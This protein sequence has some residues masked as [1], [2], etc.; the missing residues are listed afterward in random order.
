MNQSNGS[1][2]LIVENEGR[3]SIDQVASLGQSE[4]PTMAQLQNYLPD[5]G[6]LGAEIEFVLLWAS[7]DDPDMDQPVLV[8]SPEL[9]RKWAD[10]RIRREQ[11]LTK[12]FVEHLNSDD[13]AP[14]PSED[15]VKGV[16]DA[17]QYF[18]RS[19]DESRIDSQRRII[20]PPDPS[21]GEYQRLVTR[22]G[23]IFMLLLYVEK[24]LNYFLASW[25]PSLMEL[26]GELGS[27]LSKNQPTSEW[28][29]DWQAKADPIHMKLVAEKSDQGFNGLVKELEQRLSLKEPAPDQLPDNLLEEGIGNL[30]ELVEIRNAIGHSIIYNGITV[31]G[32]VLL[33]PHLTKHTSKANRRTIA[34]YFD[35]E[36]YGIVKSMIDDAHNFVFLCGEVGQL[37]PKP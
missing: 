10:Y 29:D 32:T 18:L 15:D 20:M 9:F 24:H 28:L 33:E 3:F 6:L 23:E 19:A 25:E 31:N 12:T 2:F 4:R 34:T 11:G 14:F 8:G 7:S 35:D 36:I 26:Y 1:Y 21:S 22:P 5:M 13:S 37:S 27:A 17:V 16:A 30:K